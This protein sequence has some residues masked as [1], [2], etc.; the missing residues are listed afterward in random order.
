MH[1]TLHSV[2][3]EATRIVGCSMFVYNYKSK[4]VVAV[5]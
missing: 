2:Y 4:E 3:S 1:L 5:G